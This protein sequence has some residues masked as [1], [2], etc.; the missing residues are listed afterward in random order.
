[1]Y[2]TKSIFEFN[3]DKII[4]FNS[5]YAYLKYRAMQFETSYPRSTTHGRW[6]TDWERVKLADYF[7]TQKNGQYSR[8]CLEI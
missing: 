1:M 8:S 4:F 6:E 3:T 2:A 5:W 7:D